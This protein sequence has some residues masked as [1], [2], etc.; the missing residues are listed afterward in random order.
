[1]CQERISS[2]QRIYTRTLNRPSDLASCLVLRK[3]AD[4][5]ISPWRLSGI[6][7]SRIPVVDLSSLVHYP[8][9]YTCQTAGSSLFAALSIATVKNEKRML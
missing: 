2:G 6:L 8:A 7:C 4:N 9:S 5:Y 3:A 1:M